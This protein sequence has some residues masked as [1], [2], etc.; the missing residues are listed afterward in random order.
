MLIF[1]TS[2]RLEQAALTRQN[3][4]KSILFERSRVELE[5]TFSGRAS[6][7]VKQIGNS[8]RFTHTQHHQTLRHQTHTQIGNSARFHPLHPPIQPNRLRLYKTFGFI[9]YHLPARTMLLVVWVSVMMTKC[10]LLPTK[11]LSKRLL[12]LLPLL[13]PWHLKSLV[14]KTSGSRHSCCC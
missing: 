9:P 3:G 5:S 14:L 4:V 10:L 8:A 7:L 2:C 11:K 1:T 6:R 12:P 13:P